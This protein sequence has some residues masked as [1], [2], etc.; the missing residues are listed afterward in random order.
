ML[1]TR[2]NCWKFFIDRVRRQLKVVL[3]F[4]PVGSTLRI[5][6]R[7]FP[8]I[9]NCTAI[10]WFHEWP[11][12]A[13][14]SV[15]KRFLEE[16]DVLPVSNTIINLVVHYISVVLY[17]WHINTFKY[18]YRVRGQVVSYSDPLQMNHNLHP[19]Q[20]ITVVIRHDRLSVMYTCVLKVLLFFISKLFCFDNVLCVFGLFIVKAV[21]LWR[22]AWSNVTEAVSFVC[23]N[24][25]MIQWHVSWAL[26]TCLSTRLLGYTCKMSDVT[27]T[28]PP[29]HFLNK[30][31]YIPNCSVR[32]VLNSQEGWYVW[33][34]D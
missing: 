18:P 29:S 12:E 15:S 20:N 6:A 2:E 13:L 27:I 31:A 10:N 28:P 14:V 1:D 8:A 25:T 21:I 26:F 19:Y 9:I 32:R 17:K 16:L 34:M 22:D 7:K 4:S 11:Q 30:S 33:K 24:V 23:S 3:C 5:R